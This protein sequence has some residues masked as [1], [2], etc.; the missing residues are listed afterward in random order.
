MFILKYN[1]FKTIMTAFK[2]ITISNKEYYVLK[3]PIKEWVKGH[4]IYSILEKSLKY[5]ELY[6]INPLDCVLEIQ[7]KEETLSSIVIKR[8]YFALHQSNIPKS[9][10][11]RRIM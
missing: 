1:Q 4:S 6:N 8:G 10:N 2:T 7:K 3:F 11:Y 9:F 5:I